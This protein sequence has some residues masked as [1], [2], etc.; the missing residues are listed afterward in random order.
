[1]L[2]E[3]KHGNEKFAVLLPF[4][5]KFVGVE[6]DL[7]WQYEEIWYLLELKRI[8]KQKQT[9]LVTILFL[10]VDITEVHHSD[11]LLG[12]TEYKDKLCWSKSCFSK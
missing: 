4:R 11:Q 6:I 12:I 5:G 10:Q 3:I 2:M 9:T 8:R 7:S 1:M